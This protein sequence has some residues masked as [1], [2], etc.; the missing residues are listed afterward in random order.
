MSAALNDIKNESKRMKEEVDRNKEGSNSKTVKCCKELDDLETQLNRKLND[1]ISSFKE[2]VKTFHDGNI[3]AFSCISSVCE[4]K[5]SWAIIEEGKLNEFVKNSF[6][7]RLYLMSRNFQKEVSKAKNE[8]KEA[9]YKNT[10]KSVW[11]KENTAAFK[12][13]L[14]DLTVVCELHEEVD[15]SEEGTTFSIGNATVENQKTRKELIEELIQAKLDKDKAETTKQELYDEIN[16]VKR[17]LDELE[18]KE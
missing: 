10:F 9:E 3:A 17:D 15:G 7:G 8:M 2:E 16:N 14:E 1:S 4:E 5:A 6:T 13:L 12:C 11:L 18:V